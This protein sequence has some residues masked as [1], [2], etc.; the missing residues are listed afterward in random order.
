VAAACQ[1]LSSTNTTFHRSN[2]ESHL[3]ATSLIWRLFGFGLLQCSF[4]R[5]V[6]ALN[7]VNQT[8]V[9]NCRSYQHRLTLMQ[10]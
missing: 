2:N 6:T 7:R 5:H 3:S 10:V 9:A 8:L 4:E 1:Q